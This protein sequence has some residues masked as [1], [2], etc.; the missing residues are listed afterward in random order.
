MYFF[1]TVLKYFLNLKSIIIFLCVSGS[2]G[3]RNVSRTSLRSVSKLNG[4][5][6]GVFNVINSDH[7]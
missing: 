5:K 2:R 3:E 1:K 4:K 7:A 6:T